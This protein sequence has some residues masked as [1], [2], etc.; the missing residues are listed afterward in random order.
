MLDCS[1]RV[2]GRGSLNRR[3]I[4]YWLDIYFVP[5]SRNLVDNALIISGG[6]F[7]HKRRNDYDSS[8]IGDS[9]KI[10]R[11]HLVALP[12]DRSITDVLT[13]LL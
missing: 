1:P 3:L 4:G 8:L 9:I 5:R 13:F 12:I 2:E 11:S 7:L 6:A 10:E